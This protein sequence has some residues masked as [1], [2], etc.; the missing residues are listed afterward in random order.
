MSDKKGTGKKAAGNSSVQAGSFGP[1]DLS[2]FC[3][4]LSLIFK[5]G[6]PF[7]EGMSL[8]AEEMADTRFRKLSQSVYKDVFGGMSLNESLEKQKVFPPYMVNMVKI[9]EATGTLDSELERLSVYYDKADKLNRRIRNA[10]TYPV[11][12]AILMGCIILLLILK[13]LPMFH[14]ILVS[15][16]GEIP[17]ATQAILNFS[18]GFSNNLLVIVAVIVLLALGAVILAKTT[19]G[20]R[21]WDEFKVKAPLLKN[22][23]LKIISA[24]FSMGMSML[25]KGGIA[26]DDALGM[27]RNIIDNS[28]VAQKLSDCQKEI[29]GGAD[30]SD[31]FAKIGIFPPLFVKMLNIGYKTGEMEKSLGKIAGIY[32]NE[33]DRHM[34]RVTSAIEPVL[35]IILSAVVGIILL[36]VM[37][38]LISIMSSIG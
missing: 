7:L 19:A 6:I 2:L 9:A 27:V 25:L 11:I 15:A 1:G 3:Y 36:A 20:R 31:S 5:S 16:G 32:E 21:K 18:M 24:R 23:N 17:P 35:V 13:I 4:Q 8:F 26:F 12:L 34:N 28:Y 14:E 30:T 22:I 38:P 37:L 10:I 29:T 33:V